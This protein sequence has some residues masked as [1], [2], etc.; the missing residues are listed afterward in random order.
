MVAVGSKTAHILDTNDQ[1]AHNLMSEMF[2]A[3][4][5]NIPCMKMK[6]SI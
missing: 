3:M 1:E 5:Q 6:A 2:M 4:N